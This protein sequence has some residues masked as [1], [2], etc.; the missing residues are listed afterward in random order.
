MSFLSSLF[1]GQK[2]LSNATQSLLNQLPQQQSLG[3]ANTVA[4]LN[5]TQGGVDSLDQAGD[6]F[7]NILGGSSTD[8]EKLLGPQVSTIMSQYDSAAKAAQQLGPRGG[9]RT[10]AIET[11]K[12][13]KVG[14]YGNLLG[15]AGTSAATGLAG[16]GSDVGKLGLGAAGIGTTE[17][18]QAI[19]QATGLAG[20]TNT[21]NQNIFDNASGVGQALGNSGGSFTGLL[22]GLGN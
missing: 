10:N 4:G 22:K 6:F 5:T 9:G 3:T 11:A 12:T 2:G 18:G 16:V 8:T 13:G 21:Q 1:G 20:A 15:Q 14:A 17:T 7:K 19:G